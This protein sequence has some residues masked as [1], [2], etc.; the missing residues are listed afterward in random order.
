MGITRHIVQID[1]IAPIV[2]HQQRVDH[3][4]TELREIFSEGVQLL[5]RR[6]DFE[7]HLAEFIGALNLLYAK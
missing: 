6:R 4:L 7:D 2:E 5:V 1:H 3:V